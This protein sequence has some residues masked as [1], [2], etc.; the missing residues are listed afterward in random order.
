MT[1]QTRHWAQWP[2]ICLAALSILAFSSTAD[3]QWG[4]DGAVR[5]PPGSY[6]R[7]RSYNPAYSNGYDDGYQKG[8]E[9]GRDGD[10][11]DV[12][13]HSRYRSADH[14]YRGNYG[15]RTEYKQYYRNGFEQGYERGYRDSFRNG[16]NGRGRWDNRDP[17]RRW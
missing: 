12:R 3:A 4:R 14:G 6:D 10:R 7:G 9:D 1:K 13:R 11:A 15:P 5:R 17:W 16:R 8:R 2:A